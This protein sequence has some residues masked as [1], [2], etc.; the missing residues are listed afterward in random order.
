MQRP[1]M[2]EKVDNSNS[3]A[4]TDVLMTAINHCPAEPGYTLHLQTV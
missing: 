1:T 3:A 4:D 2:T